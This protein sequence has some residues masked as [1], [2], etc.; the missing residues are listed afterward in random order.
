MHHIE[1]AAIQRHQRD[2]QQIGKGDA[3]QF[4]REPALLGLIGKAGRQDAHRLRHEQPGHHQ[5]NHLRQ[6]QQREDAIGEQPRRDLAALAVDMGIGRHERGVERALGKDRPEMI[7]QPERHEK[8]IRDRA[9]AEN[10]G[11]HD[12]AGEAGQPRKKRI[13]ADG[14]DTSEHAPLLAY[15]AAL[16]NGEIRKKAR[17]A[18]P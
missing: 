4:D 15:A 17:R 10:R 6:K 1:H 16:Q 11:E 5:Q 13:A 7:G 3:R 14:E 18:Q 9:G 12:V 8:R 2:Q